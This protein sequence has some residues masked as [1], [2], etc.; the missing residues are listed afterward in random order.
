MTEP[1]LSFHRADRVGTVKA[2]ELLTEKG[3]FGR[4]ANGD[5]GSPMQRAVVAFQKDHKLEPDGIVGAET[6]AALASTKKPKKAKK[7]AAEK[8]PA[9]KPAA[10]KAPAKK[11]AAKKK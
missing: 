9:K 3:Y 5:F 4:R 10:K 7:A 2:Q 11:A 1:I 6:W 8:A